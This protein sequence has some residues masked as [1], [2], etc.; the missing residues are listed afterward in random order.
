M[1]IADF[2]PLPRR[3]LYAVTGGAGDLATL[4][5]QVEAAID[6]GAVMVQYRDK[7]AS[8]AERAQRA[9]ALVSACHARG[10]PL[11]VNDDVELAVASAAAGVHLGRDDGSLARARA[12]LGAGRII[13]VSCYDSLDSAYLAVAGGASYV[14]FGSCF[15]SRTKPHARSC[16]LDIFAAAAAA[17]TVPVVAIGGITPENAGLVLTAG[18]HLLAVIGALFDSDESTAAARAF[19]RQF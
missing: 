10:V 18:A 2:P 3:G 17:L 5:R 15:E 14:A 11:V 6:G 7:A 12:R 1:T 13:G 8:A 19:A 4:R 9:P 16:D